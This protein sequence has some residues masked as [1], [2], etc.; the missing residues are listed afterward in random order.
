M[1][2]EEKNVPENRI[3]LAALSFG[4]TDL[5]FSL[6]LRPVL[7]IYRADRDIFSP[8]R[9]YWTVVS[10]KLHETRSMSRES[11]RRVARI[12]QR[13]TRKYE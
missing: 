1:I 2:K 10:D 9:R 3:G 13:G 11:G 8:S 4:T 5:S 12:S 7:R 6:L